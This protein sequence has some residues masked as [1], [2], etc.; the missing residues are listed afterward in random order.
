MYTETHTVIDRFFSVIFFSSEGDM[1]F[2][3][4]IGSEQIKCLPEVGENDN[5]SIH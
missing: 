1:D 2:Q 3:V 5:S 4:C